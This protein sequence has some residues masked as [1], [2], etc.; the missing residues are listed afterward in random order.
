[1]FLQSRVPRATGSRPGRRPAVSV[2][3][4]RPAVSKHRETGTRSSAHACSSCWN[5]VKQ[6]PTCSQ[7]FLALPLARIYNT[8]EAT[9]NERAS[10]ALVRAAKS[11]FRTFGA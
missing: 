7:L 9:D 6:F 1:M 10:R 5:R 11:S 8:R 4:R 2:P 3:V